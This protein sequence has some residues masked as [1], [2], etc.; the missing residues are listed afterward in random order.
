MPT[1]IVSGSS[2]EWNCSNP[3][4]VDFWYPLPIFLKLAAQPYPS[5]LDGLRTSLILVWRFV[6]L[7]RSVDLSRTYRTI[8]EP[9]GKL[10]IRVQRKRKRPLFDRVMELPDPG[11]SPAHSLRDYVQKMA[12]LVPA[13]EPV[14]VSLNAPFAP[15][16]R[17]NHWLY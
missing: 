1:P 17:N 10:Y 2:R 13:K 9:D 16:S 3:R 14:L 8:C 15:I 11:I 7:Y 5:T 12:H 4:D 6:G